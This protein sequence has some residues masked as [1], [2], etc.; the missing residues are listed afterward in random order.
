[1][2][3][4]LMYQNRDRHLMSDIDNI[5]EN[6]S[7]KTGKFNHLKHFYHSK[8][9]IIKDSSYMTFIDSNI[10]RLKS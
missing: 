10:N 6:R 1:M 7:L 8:Y 9:Q 3:L 5:L 2:R 4:Y